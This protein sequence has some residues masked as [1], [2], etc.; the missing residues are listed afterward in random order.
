M[1][2]LRREH[3]LQTTAATVAAPSGENT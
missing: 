1:F 3:T 2:Y